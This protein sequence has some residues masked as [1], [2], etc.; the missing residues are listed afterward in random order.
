[1]GTTT[2]PGTRFLYTVDRSS[3]LFLIATIFISYTI[4]A[5]F[6]GLVYYLMENYLH[7]GNAAIYSTKHCIYHV[8]VDSYGN[9]SN[10]NISFVGTIQ[11]AFETQSTIGY[12]HHY[13][14]FLGSAK[15]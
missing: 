9:I 6:F 4:S 3:W 12:G 5:V 8:E 11:F 1:M 15:M 13:R 2:D 7:W 14:R 10:G